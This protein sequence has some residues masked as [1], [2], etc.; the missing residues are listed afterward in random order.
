MGLFS[1]L[2]DL[3]KVINPDLFYDKEVVTTRRPNE[4]YE[5]YSYGLLE[6]Y[7]GDNYLHNNFY[8]YSSKN[9]INFLAVKKGSI[10][11]DIVTNYKIEEDNVVEDMLQN[12]EFDK[13]R[14]TLN[15][16]L[17]AREIKQISKE[18]AARIIYYLKSSKIEEEYKNE[19][20]GLIRYQAER[21][22]NRINYS[23]KKYNEDSYI[24]NNCDS[25]VDKYVKK[26]IK[27]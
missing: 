4:E 8:S 24:H 1:G 26:R 16:T 21:L 15:R 25:I 20:Y 22:I 2:R 23:E 13:L 11:E 9:R 3:L 6:F 27:R 18:E 14:R 17:Y 5:F 10:I 12:H 19:F 7:D